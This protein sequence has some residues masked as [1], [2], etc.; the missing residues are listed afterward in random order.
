MSTCIDFCGG[1]KKRNKKPDGK[2]EE[3]KP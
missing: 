1:S 3:V 2:F